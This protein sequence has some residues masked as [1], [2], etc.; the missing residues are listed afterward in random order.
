MK[1]ITALALASIMGLTM[2]ACGGKS[3][4]LTPTE[5]EA[6]TAAETVAET[7]AETEGEDEALEDVAGAWIGVQVSMS[8]ATMEA[9]EFGGDVALVLQ[10]DGTGYMIF[11]G[12]AMD[13]FTWK[14]NDTGVLIGEGGIY[15]ECPIEDGQLILEVTEDGN[16]ARVVYEKGELSD[17]SDEVVEAIENDDTTTEIGYYDKEYE[18]G[19]YESSNISAIESGDAVVLEGADGKVTGLIADNE[20]VKIELTD[21]YHSDEYEAWVLQIKAENKTDEVL[22]VMVS[23]SAVNGVMS[24][25]GFG[26]ELEPGESLEDIGGWMDYELEAYGIS[27]VTDVELEVVVMNTD[28]DFVYQGTV[29]AY[30]NGEA[31]A[32]IATREDKDTDQLLYEDDYVKV[33]AT[34]KGSSDYYDN[35]VQL[36]VVNKTDKSIYVGGEDVLVNGKDMD[37]YWGEDLAAGKAVYSYMYWFD[38]ELQEQG[39]ES[40][41]SLE[42]KLEVFDNVNF[43]TLVK[44]DALT[45]DAASLPE[46]EA[47]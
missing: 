41:D 9:S 14:T 32:T 47:Q 19:D 26:V 40:I 38:D 23:D 37:P 16:T 12:Q 11:P 6:G 1:K 21:T 2:A 29:K 43:D 25:V 3:D 33:L 10:E 30:P 17:L 22:S 13:K 44:T 18:T 45:I 15:Y 46:G 34:E 28:Y 24:P 35:Y 5:T 27:E 36:Y 39:I 31:N 42:L 20:L 8:G 7:V 4:V